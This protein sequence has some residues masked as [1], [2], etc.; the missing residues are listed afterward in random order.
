MQGWASHTKI[1]Y[2][3]EDLLTQALKGKWVWAST[4]VGRKDVK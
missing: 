1:Q 2:I 3:L 4:T